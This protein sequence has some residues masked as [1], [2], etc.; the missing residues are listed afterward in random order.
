ML[1]L[2]IPVRGGFHAKVRA[3]S[4]SPA[5]AEF[6]SYQSKAVRLDHVLD[7]LASHV[8]DSNIIANVEDDGVDFKINP[9][10]E[11]KLRAAGASQKLIQSVRYMAGAKLPEAEDKEL[12]V[13][14]ILHL[15]E[16]GA[17]AKDRLFTLIQQ[18]G[19]NFRLDRATEERLRQGGAN[20]KLM[21]AIGDAADHYAAT[22]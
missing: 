17:V 13:S 16:D 12:S 14:Q 1:N 21:R 20:E 3:A 19:V 7:L 10:V 22:H 6:R 9:E 8:P 15:M 11:E 18:R 4:H 2:H 5:S